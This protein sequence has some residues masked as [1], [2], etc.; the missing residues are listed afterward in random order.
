MLSKRIISL[1][2]DNSVA[3]PAHPP[4]RFSYSIARS[5]RRGRLCRSRSVVGHLRRPLPTDQLRVMRWMDDRHASPSGCAQSDLKLEFWNRTPC[6]SQISG[7][8]RW[9]HRQS[10]SSCERVHDSFQDRAPIRADA[11]VLVQ[12]LTRDLRWRGK[13]APPPSSSQVL[14]FSDFRPPA[15]PENFRSTAAIR[16]RRRRR[17]PVRHARRD[18][19]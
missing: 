1:R 13:T 4:I 18:D 5:R 15:A 16:E 9:H 14:L 2:L 10:A 6:R 8:G 7:V 3:R 12:L 11:A 17:R 19:G